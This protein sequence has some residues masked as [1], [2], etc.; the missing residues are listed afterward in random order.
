[1]PKQ[2]GDNAPAKGFRARTLVTA[3]LGLKLGTKAAKSALNIGK[4][5]MDEDQAIA[6][7]SE[8]ME[9]IDG[10]KG[11][12]MKFG[13]MAS[14]LGTSFPPNAQRLL[15]RLQSEASAMPFDTV[16]PILE[17]ELGGSIDSI[18]ES[19]EEDAFAAASIGQVHRAELNGTKVA[20][21]IQYPGIED[22]IRSDLGTIGSVLLVA[23][24]GARQ[25]GKGL[26]RELRQRL[27]EECDYR[28]EA[29]NQQ[30]F[31]CLR[32]TPAW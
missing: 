8:L 24:T 2:K 14:Y 12:V 28:N 19:F 26:T 31:A 23:L 30:H 17:E 22:A 18:F 4:G 9:D 16:K 27:L 25:D 6:L 20:V 29:R 13:Q 7:A 10:L 15:A 11:L 32:T 1:M 3:R 21:K 5:N